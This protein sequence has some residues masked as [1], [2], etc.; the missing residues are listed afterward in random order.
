MRTLALIVVLVSA[1]LG[2]VAAPTAAQGITGQ[3]YAAETGAP[4]AGAHVF[5]AG[6]LQGTTTAADGR[7]AL[8]G[9]PP[10]SHDVVFSH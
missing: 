6:S 2:G 1:L 4:L 9:V 8:T 7:F 10:G 3:V 5:I